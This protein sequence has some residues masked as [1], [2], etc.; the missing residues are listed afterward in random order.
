MYLDSG[1]K[2]S[3]SGPLDQAVIHNP[4]TRE[5]MWFYG[6]SSFTLR[7]WK[8]T[9]DGKGCVYDGVPYEE[10]IAGE[11]I[12]N[13]RFPDRDK[14]TGFYHGM[15]N[16]PARLKEEFRQSNERYRMIFKKVVEDLKKANKLK[17]A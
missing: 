2:G 16:L 4:E 17:R 6:E 9:E 1:V 10:C 14:S 5:E 7:K 13:L 12:V 8:K 3:I 11:A 15:P